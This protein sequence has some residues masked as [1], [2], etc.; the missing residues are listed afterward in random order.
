MYAFNLTQPASVSD[1]RNICLLDEIRNEHDF[2]DIIGNS[3]SLRKV[4][5]FTS[6]PRPT[7]PC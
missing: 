2:G 4:R 6:L 5:E 3:L 1:T 7:R